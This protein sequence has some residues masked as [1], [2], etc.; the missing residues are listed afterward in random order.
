MAA[1]EQALA[2]GLRLGTL[3]G[4]LTVHWMWRRPRWQAPHVPVHTCLQSGSSRAHGE[5]HG[6]EETSTPHS[7]SDSCPHPG[8]VFAT[9]NAVRLYRQSWGYKPSSCT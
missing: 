8:H 4:A 1:D 7:V 3:M 5:G 2:H 9:C 6:V